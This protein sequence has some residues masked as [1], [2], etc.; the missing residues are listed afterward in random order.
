MEVLCCHGCGKPVQWVQGVGWSHVDPR[1]D[2]G[3][4]AYRIPQTLLD[5]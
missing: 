1:D 4:H 5:H 3:C 2:E